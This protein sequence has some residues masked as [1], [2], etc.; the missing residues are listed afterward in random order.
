MPTQ[1]I[2]LIGETVTF[3]REVVLG[4]DKPRPAP[5]SA[6]TPLGS[7]GVGTS[8]GG[9]GTTLVIAA[10]AAGATYLVTKR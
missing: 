6:A 1:N 4:V 5:R 2:D 7:A 8:D 3:L 10:L 9:F